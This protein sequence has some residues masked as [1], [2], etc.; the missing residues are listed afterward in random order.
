[1][2]SVKNYFELQQI[3]SF[4]RQIARVEQSDRSTIGE[5]GAAHR[6]AEKPRAHWVKEGGALKMVWTI[7]AVRPPDT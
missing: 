7:G 3:H 6:P 5:C 2:V 4:N 1:M